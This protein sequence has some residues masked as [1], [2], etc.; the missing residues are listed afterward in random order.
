MVRSGGKYAV[1]L[2]VVLLPAPA[3]AD[4]SGDLGA[5]LAVQA[6]QGFGGQ[7]PVVT[8]LRGHGDEHFGDLGP[9]LAP[10]RLDRHRAGE[11]K[12]HVNLMDVKASLEENLAID[13]FNGSNY[14]TGDAFGHAS[15]LPVAV[16]NSGNNVIIQ[17]AFILNLDVK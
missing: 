8:G 4:G 11:S 5:A 6:A 9:A 14:I 15:G 16:Q 1:A 12:L 2:A 7:Q 13:T 3:W 10:E 17:N